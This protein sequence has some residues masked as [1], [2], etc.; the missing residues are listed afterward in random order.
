MA[1]NIRLSLHD[2][3]KKALRYQLDG[4]RQ[5]QYKKANH[6]C[7][8]TKKCKAK[9]K[10][11]QLDVHHMNISF[12]EVINISHKNLGI[13][14]HEFKHQYNEGEFEKITQEVIRIHQ[15]EVEAVVLE[16]WMHMRLHERY[17]QNFT[18]EQLKE[19]KYSYRTNLYKSKNGNYR[20]KSA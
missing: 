20:K 14:R 4:W 15:E 19:Y 1:Y 7:Y 8:I 10:R 2:N 18:M 16:H 11:L 3:V 13:K 17:G 6:T 9:D 5:E 12:E